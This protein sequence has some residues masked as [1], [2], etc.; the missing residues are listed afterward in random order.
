MGKNYG[1]KNIE[2]YVWSE[3]G[4]QL[5]MR[6]DGQSVMWYQSDQTELSPLL[7]NLGKLN[8]L[9]TDVTE[10]IYQ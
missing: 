1:Y 3:S 5:K 7:L 9:V 4:V 6:R 8:C 2:T 10:M